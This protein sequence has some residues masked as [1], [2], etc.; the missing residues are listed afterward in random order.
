MDY[1]AHQELKAS[2]KK[3]AQDAIRAKNKSLLQA[4]RGRKEQELN[5]LIKRI[6]LPMTFMIIGAL[7]YIFIK[8][9]F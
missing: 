8:Q 1:R 7:I 2:G 3:A 4:E 9:I 6:I 5:N